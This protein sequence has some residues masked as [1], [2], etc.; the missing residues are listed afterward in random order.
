MTA[1]FV[2]LSALVY[3][4][5]DIPN[6]ESPNLGFDFSDKIVHACVFFIYGISAQLVVLTWMP[7][8]TALFRVMVAA[9]ISVVFAA[10]D[11]LHQLMVP[12][13]TGALD[14]F[15]ADTIGIALSLLFASVLWKIVIQLHR[16]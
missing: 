1:Q 10:S 13:R 6:L 12:G 9:F 5:S 11:E 8:K 7:N 2:V 14:D 4:L 3:W 16:R 15:I